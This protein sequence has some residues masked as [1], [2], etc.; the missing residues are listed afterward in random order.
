MSTR[1]HGTMYIALPI[2]RSMLSWYLVLE[3][4]ACGKHVEL[5]IRNRVKVRMQVSACR[6]KGYRWKKNKEGPLQS[7]VKETSSREVE[8]AP[9]TFMRRQKAVSEGRVCCVLHTT[10]VRYCTRGQD[11]VLPRGI[12]SIRR[13]SMQSISMLRTVLRSLWD[14][15]LLGVMPRRAHLT[16]PRGCGLHDLSF[17][18]ALAV[19]PI[20]TT[21]TWGSS[22]SLGS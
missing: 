1:Y 6:S 17:L 8:L 14:Y 16:L 19:H 2:P 22:R 9:Q 7:V 15:T 4:L 3:A 21:D 5:S 13:W 11:M 10:T 12:Y 20:L 18:L